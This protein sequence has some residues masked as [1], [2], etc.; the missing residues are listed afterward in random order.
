MSHAGWDIPLLCQKNAL[1]DLIERSLVRLGSIV[2]T[3]NE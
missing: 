2:V 3:I 1:F